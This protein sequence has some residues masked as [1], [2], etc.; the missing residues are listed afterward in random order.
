MS[1]HIYGIGFS[2][3][4][5]QAPAAW[6]QIVIDN[7]S[8][9][10]DSISIG[11]NSNVGSVV[12]DGQSVDAANAESQETGT[13]TVTLANFNSIRVAIA[14][15]VT[16][17]QGEPAAA[18]L[19]GE[20]RVLD[21]VAFDITGNQL[22]IR[23]STSFSTQQPLKIELVAPHVEA[24]ALDASGQIEVRDVAESKLTLTING[25]GDISANGQVA[26]LTGLI[27]GAGDLK[28]RRLEAAQADVTVE[29]AG[30]VEVTARQRLAATIN[31]SGDIVYFGEPAAVTRNINGAGLIQ[32]DGE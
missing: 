30:N 11:K 2:L 16:I 13:K 7:Q 27:S 24:V 9:N 21:K 4:I 25:A 29:G 18:T 32:A 31:G 6:A 8:I 1:K 17:S 22:T 28:L 19:S 10:V 3:L 26:N 20:T 14:A 15:D 5:L 12:I 23:P